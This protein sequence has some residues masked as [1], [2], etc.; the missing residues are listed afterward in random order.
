[1]AHDLIHTGFPR[2]SCENW[3]PPIFPCSCCPSRFPPLQR[4]K[5]PSGIPEG[6]ATTF[7]CPKCNPNANS[8]PS[9]ETAVLPEFGRPNRCSPRTELQQRDLDEFPHDRR[10]AKSVNCQWMCR[11][12]DHP[13]RIVTLASRNACQGRYFFNA[14]WHGVCTTRHM[15]LKSHA[16]QTARVWADRKLLTRH[17]LAS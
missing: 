1:M 16:V 11:F 13:R 9:Q 12:T 2:G 4:L 6:V 7:H 15:G 14:L 17:A 8:G 5:N 3:S 10:L